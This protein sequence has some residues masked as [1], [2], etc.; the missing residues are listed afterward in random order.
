M[1][2]F[3]GRLPTPVRF[4]GRALVTSFIMDVFVHPDFQ[5]RRLGLLLLRLLWTRTPDAI[6]TSSAGPAMQKLTR[7]FDRIPIASFQRGWRLPVE[8]RPPSAG[9]R[10][11]ARL[12]KWIGVGTRG[13]LVPLLSISDEMVTQ[14]ARATAGATFHVERTRA[15]LDWRFGPPI[16]AAA[17][18][19][20][21]LGA[22]VGSR[23]V[24]WIVVRRREATLEVL[25]WL[26]TPDR[27]SDVL[28]LV[29]DRARALGCGSVTGRG[30]QATLHAAA[31][32][33]GAAPT[34][35]IGLSWTWSP[36]LSAFDGVDW[37]QAYLSATDGDL[38]LPWNLDPR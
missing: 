18:E 32:S 15:Y 5:A 7:Y 2:G 13:D 3:V 24:G 36:D 35:E 28:G 11:R 30:M 29:V 34:T 16:R 6:F 9:G 12:G 25:D 20:A 10:M 19:C 27:H 1:V 22:V 8:P 26:A 17:P 38:T 33:L 31:L 23:S 21:L 14:A 4:R 37:E